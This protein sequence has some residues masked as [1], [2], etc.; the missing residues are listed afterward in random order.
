MLCRAQNRAFTLIEL[1]VCVA[2]TAVLL[3]LATPGANALIKRSAA[4]RAINWLVTGVVFTRHAAVSF[5]ETVTYCPS[6]DGHQCG[7]K[8]HE[9][10]IAFTDSNMDHHVNGHD[11]ILKRFSFPEPGATITWRAFQNRQYLQM[12][13]QG[14]TNYQNGNFTYCPPDNDPRYARQLVVNRQGRT[15][16]S[17]DVDADGIV[18]NVQGHDL[19]CPD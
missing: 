5:G 14:F 8:W 11:A 18:E 1:L 7:G 6:Q 4:T 16:V 17:H 19:V 12:T 15:R 10:A 13:R 2:I 9:G 3:G